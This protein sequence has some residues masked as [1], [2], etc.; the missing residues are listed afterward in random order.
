[1]D[2][3]LDIFLIV[4]TNK[5]ELWHNS[6]G[7]I[8]LLHSR[9]D[10]TLNALAVYDS[11]HPCIFLVLR[12]FLFL[13]FSRASSHTQFLQIFFFF[14]FKCL[15]M[16]MRCSLL[17][18]VECSWEFEWY[19]VELH[20]LSVLES[21]NAFWCIQIVWRSFTTFNDSA[22]VAALA[23]NNHLLEEVRKKI[24]SFYEMRIFSLNISLFISTNWQI[25]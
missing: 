22:K 12:T 6:I 19:I 24:N 8:F 17:N 10:S 16:K 11:F 20:I 25:F 23:F 7:Y 3:C 18:A 4:C 13:L 21:F 2:G 9:M 14:N 5:T 1:M 15:N